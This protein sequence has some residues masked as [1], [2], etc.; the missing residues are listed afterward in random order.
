MAKIPEKYQPTV[1]PTKDEAL[2][3]AIE[4]EDW[5]KRARDRDQPGSAKEF[6][7]TALLLRFYKDHSDGEEGHV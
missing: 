3:M 6:E 5:A 7:L 2:N 4:R 1:L